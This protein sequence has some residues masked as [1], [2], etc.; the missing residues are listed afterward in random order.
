MTFDMYGCVRLF[1]FLQMIYGTM[2]IVIHVLLLS[3]PFNE[4]RCD[5]IPGSGPW[6]Q[7]LDLQ[8][9]LRIRGNGDENWETPVLRYNEHGNFAGTILGLIVGIMT[10]LLSL[11][12]DC[13]LQKSGQGRLQPLAKI[14]LGFTTLQIPAFLACNMG[15]LGTLCN[16]DEEDM[17][18][19]RLFPKVAGHCGVLT[20]WYV[21]WTL[22]CSSIA[23]LG[24][25]VCWSFV[26]YQVQANIG[27][28]SQGYLASE[29]EPRE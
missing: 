10:F 2:L 9:S 12:A 17:G 3:P 23:A 27:E 24:L 20:L 21:E 19:S 29:T 25:W 4:P 6:L 16:Y 14:W 26:N 11:I 8:W 18:V 1:I 5:W 15:K 13:S 22:M 7:L 28:Y